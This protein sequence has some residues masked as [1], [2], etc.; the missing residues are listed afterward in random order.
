[1]AKTKPINQQK[2][3]S[4]KQRITNLERGLFNLNQILSMY[5]DYNEDAKGFQ[6]FLKEKMEMAKK[7]QESLKNE[8]TEKQAEG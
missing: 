6:R 1:M 3:P 8:E 7:Q 5:V 4:T 2:Q